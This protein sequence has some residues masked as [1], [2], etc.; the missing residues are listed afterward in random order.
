[1]SRLHDIAVDPVERSWG[2][3]GYISSAQMDSRKPL[4]YHWGSKSL[5]NVYQ[6]VVDIAPGSGRGSVELQ[7]DRTL[8]SLV[9]P[10]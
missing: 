3:L 10:P 1:M 9:V 6:P 4:C 2:L 5:E 7:G 8:P